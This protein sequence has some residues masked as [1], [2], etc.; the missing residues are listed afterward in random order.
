MGS[1]FETYRRSFIATLEVGAMKVFGS[2][3]LWQG[4][5][6]IAYALGLATNAPTSFGYMILS[7]VG[8]SLGVIINTIVYLSAKCTIV[9]LFDTCFGVR[10]V[11]SNA[12]TEEQ[13]AAA[14]S[15]ILIPSVAS[16]DFSGYLHEEFFVVQFN[17][18]L[19]AFA[20]L[21]S[22]TFWGYWV[23]EFAEAEFSLW[24]NC[25]LTGL[26]T[27]IIFFAGLRVGRSI[28][29]SA[30][31]RVH[32]FSTPFLRDDALLSFVGIYGAEAFFVF[33]KHSDYPASALTDI[34]GTDHSTF[35]NICLAGAST[36]SGFVCARA[37][38][39]HPIEWMVEAMSGKDSTEEEQSS[40]IA[41]PLP[42]EEM[43]ARQDNI[44]DSNIP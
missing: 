42:G 40:L 18:L 36:F 5:A 12:S 27:A 26:L 34:F 41:K 44:R 9:Y 16:Q 33:T 20:A 14:D 3:A 4:G 23:A 7:G 21:F 37:V 29:L 28:G 2:G 8:D 11:L 32:I 6:E 31:E 22:G 43:V 38:L 19:I 24:A 25:M 13:A 15:E 17:A 35:A 30:G 10:H 1:G 39:Q